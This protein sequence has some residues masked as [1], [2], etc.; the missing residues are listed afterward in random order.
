MPW[1]NLYNN[2]TTCLARRVSSTIKHKTLAVEI[3]GSRLICQGFMILSADNFYPNY[4][5]VQGSQSTN[6]LSTKMLIG[7]Q[8]SSKVFYC[9]SFVP[10][11]TYL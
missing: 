3:G 6:V 5:A 11:G 8:Q 9:Q 10:Y 4:F 2:C 7:M 1:I